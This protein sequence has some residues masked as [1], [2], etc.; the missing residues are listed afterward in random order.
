M[1]KAIET[2][3]RTLLNEDVLYDHIANTYFYQKNRPKTAPTKIKNG[4]Y[5]RYLRRLYIS[6]SILAVVAIFLVWLGASYFH[7][8][9]LNAMKKTVNASSTISIITDGLFN[10]NII[11]NFEFRGYAKKGSTISG[12][13]IILNTPKKYNWADFSIDFKFPIN[14]EKSKLLLSLRGNIGGEKVNIVL[15]D[16]NNRSARS[17]DLSL[18]SNWTDKVFDLNSMN[19]AVDLSSIDHMRIEYGH[20]GESIKDMD[21]PIDITIFV[22]TITILK[23][24]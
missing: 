18:P 1:T 8:K 10:R 4:T 22:K 2:P 17:N 19:G 21:S 3:K 7:A 9:H 5:L 15:R 11:K 14:F 24:G 13:S 16:T 20:V 6:L 23:E 12:N